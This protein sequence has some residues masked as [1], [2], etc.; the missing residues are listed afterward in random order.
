MGTYIIEL[1]KVKEKLESLFANYSRPIENTS[2]SETQ[3]S[4]SSQKTP[5][6]TQSIT[7]IKSQFLQ[8]QVF[9]LTTLPICI[10]QYMLLS[11]HYEIYDHLIHLHRI[12]THLK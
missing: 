3:T 4:Q 6:T 5:S 12:M 1:E 8:V 11:F 9:Y 10:L 2:T 7:M